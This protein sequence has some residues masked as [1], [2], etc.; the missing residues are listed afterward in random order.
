MSHAVLLVIP[1]YLIVAVTICGFSQLLLT[2]GN[3]VKLVIG[4]FFETQTLVEFKKSL[5]LIN[6]DKISILFSIV[7]Y[8][9]FCCTEQGSLLDLNF[10]KIKLCYS[11]LYNPS[12]SSKNSQKFPLRVH[13]TIA[14]F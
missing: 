2:I 11:H 9:N 4:M 12:I 8:M 13:Y 10:V 7:V 5:N 6:T 3:N 1:I 14:L